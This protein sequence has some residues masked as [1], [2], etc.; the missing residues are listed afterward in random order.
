MDKIIVGSILAGGVYHL[1]FGMFHLVFPF[2][3]RW[4]DSLAHLDRTNRNLLPVFNLWIAFAIFAW[5]GISL[6]YPEQVAQTALGHG[7]CWSI[8]GIWTFRHMMQVYLMGFSGSY[9]FPQP[10]LGLRGVHALVFVPIFSLGTALYLMP[11]LQDDLSNW[12]MALG[13][14]GGLLFAS[15]LARRAR[16][17]S[18]GMDRDRMPSPLKGIA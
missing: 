14:T 9:V 6:A 17:A 10:F 3:L 15:W 18:F 8:A 12:A 2:A 13:V 4:K 1:L 7:I 11:M 16:S 5:S